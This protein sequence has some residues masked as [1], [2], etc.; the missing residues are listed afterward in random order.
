MTTHFL[1]GQR[2]NKQS[3]YNRPLKMDF[4]PLTLKGVLQKSPSNILK[5]YF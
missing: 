5:Y 1:S 3:D 2:V 4:K